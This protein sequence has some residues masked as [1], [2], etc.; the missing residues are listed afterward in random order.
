MNAAWRRARAIARASVLPRFAAL[1]R[2]AEGACG[3]M[4]RSQCVREW[5]SGMM[6]ASR[7][8]RPAVKASWWKTGKTWKPLPTQCCWGA[9]RSWRTERIEGAAFIPRRISAIRPSAKGRRFAGSPK[10]DLDAD[11]NAKTL[12]KT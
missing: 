6:D 7:G 8:E 10:P 1:A 11:W 12:R 2:W 4:Q 3:A 5:A 9:G